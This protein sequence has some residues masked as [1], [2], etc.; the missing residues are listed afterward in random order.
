MKYVNLGCGSRYRPDWT[1]IDIVSCG[2]GVIAHD[3]NKGIPLPDASCD[4]VYHSNLLEHL[5][6]ADALPFLR[7]NYRVLK[8]G[9]ILR[10]AVPD[11]E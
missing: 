8:P 6:Q 2:P 11:L 3:L 4:V 10:I 7:E 1:N 5:Q 9:G